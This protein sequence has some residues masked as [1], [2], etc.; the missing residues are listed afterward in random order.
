M[1]IALLFVF[2]ANNGNC[3]GGSAVY[4]EEKAIPL[5][6]DEIEKT[7]IYFKEHYGEDFEYIFVDD[8]SSDDKKEGDK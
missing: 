2:I 8:G 4:N 7:R 1:Y 3:S 5:F 6:I